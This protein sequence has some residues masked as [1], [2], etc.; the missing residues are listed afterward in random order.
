MQEHE[1]LDVRLLHLPGQACGKPVSTALRL[2]T[3]GN[4]D[5]GRLDLCLLF[6]IASAA[7]FNTSN[8]NVVSGLV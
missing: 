3:L 5:A 2:P 6:I 4:Q 1:P 7:L 8:V